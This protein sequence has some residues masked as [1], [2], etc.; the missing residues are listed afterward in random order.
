MDSFPFWVGLFSA[1]VQ[2]ELLSNPSADG[3]RC[4]GSDFLL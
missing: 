2:V 3:G 1:G 4:E